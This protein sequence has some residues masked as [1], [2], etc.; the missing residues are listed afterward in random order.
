[1]PI[2]CIDYAF[3]HFC[4]AK[5]YQN[6]FCCRK[7]PVITAEM[8]SD[9]KSRFTRSLCLEKESLILTVTHKGNCP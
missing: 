2:T 7:Q 3:N 8:V 6:S 4:T 9:A 1:M 5:A